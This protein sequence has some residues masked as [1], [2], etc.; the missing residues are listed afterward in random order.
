M[1]N[2]KKIT[3]I[4][5]VAFS[6]MISA[7]STY[8]TQQGADDFFD[9]AINNSKQSQTQSPTAINQAEPSAK[10]DTLAGLVNIGFGWIRS[11]FVEEKNQ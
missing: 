4:A 9:G 3:T 11:L 1:H 8:S 10:A 7:C 5:A 2:T 6:L